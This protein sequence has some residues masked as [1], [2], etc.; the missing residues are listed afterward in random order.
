MIASLSLLIFSVTGVCFAVT[1]VLLVVQ[2][3]PAFT[4]TALLE[5]SHTP[6]TPQ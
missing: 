1:G 6:V 3:H 2:S 5:S 4:V